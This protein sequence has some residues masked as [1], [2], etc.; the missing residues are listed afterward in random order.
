M[1]E[2]LR[3]AFSL[4]IR[5]AFQEGEKAAKN[6][7]ILARTYIRGLFWLAIIFILVPIPVLL[8][9]IMSAERWLVAGAGLVWFICAMLVFSVGA[10]L[11][12][13]F[14]AVQEG[15]KGSAVRYEKTFVGI[16]TTGLYVS[17]LFSIIPIA[18]NLSYFPL[19]ILV[20]LILGFY[21]GFLFKK[22]F[23][24][25]VATLIFLILLFTFF[26][27]SQHQ[28]LINELDRLNRPKLE[29]L[30][31]ETVTAPGFAFFR[32]NGD[33][34]Y[35][36]ALKEDGSYEIF[37]RKGH[38]PITDGELL[39]LNRGAAQ[40]FVDQLLDIK[41]RREKKK[42]EEEE[43]IAREAAALAEAQ[44]KNSLE[45]IVNKIANQIAEEVSAHN[46][47]DLAIVPF[48]QLTSNEISALGID[49][50]DRLIEFFSTQSKIRLIDIARVSEA[51]GVPDAAKLAF[52]S[53]S[54]ITKLKEAIGVRSLLRG[55][56]HDLDGDINISWNLTDTSSG[57]FYAAASETVK[58]DPAIRQLLNKTVFITYPVR[59]A[60]S[61]PAEPEEPQRTSG[62]PIET[63]NPPTKVKNAP[64]RP[65]PTPAPPVASAGNPRVL[66]FDDIRLRLNT[67][68]PTLSGDWRDRYDR[69]TASAAYHLVEVT[70]AVI[71]ED[72]ITLSLK[73]TNFTNKTAY[74]RTNRVKTGEYEKPFIK[75]R[76]GRKYDCTSFE[77]Y[78]SGRIKLA[79]KVP[80][81]GYIKFPN[82][83]SSL[84]VN[85]T[86]DLYIQLW[87]SSKRVRYVQFSA[88]NLFD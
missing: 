72:S 84:P 6:A 85:S 14:E 57:R 82:F 21:N 48:T 47:N 29:V 56:I 64:Y 83:L 69:T 18:A 32:S 13:L 45:P 60:E 55:R 66:D 53:F 9:G 75:D 22:G 16:F 2:S 65:T 4:L 87:D 31:Y 5:A 24:I 38:H 17:M 10:P 71:R 58:N 44:K 76:R 34:I 46:M 41:E 8:I 25:G 52:L 35:W 78:A 62:L 61:E 27:P 19:L 74:L 20:L 42:K 68:Q 36:Y 43:R 12:I 39:P 81:E 73:W 33:N 67:K 86:V 59:P 26:F 37:D 51:L 28:K 50:Q 30:T 49:V 79:P 1:I 3:R 77:P 70:R 88:I 80:V 63:P 15:T 23:I 7:G 54:Q 11:G 40:R